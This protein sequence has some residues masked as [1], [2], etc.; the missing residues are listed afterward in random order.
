M[1]IC[2]IVGP[3]LHRAF[4]QSIGLDWETVRFLCD[5]EKEMKK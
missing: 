3:D 2:P 4:F 1:I 5:D